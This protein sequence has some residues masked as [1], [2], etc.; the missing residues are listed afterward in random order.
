MLSLQEILKT[1]LQYL[2]KTL[3]YYKETLKRATDL[4]DKKE[5]FVSQKMWTVCLFKWMHATINVLLGGK[6]TPKK[7]FEDVT[8]TANYWV[9]STFLFLHPL[10]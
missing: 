3:H 9:L 7:T 6:M 2:K 4:S 1:F 5:S 8:R 10:K